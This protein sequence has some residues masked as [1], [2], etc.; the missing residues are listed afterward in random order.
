MISTMISSWMC[1]LI[2]DVIS[3]VRRMGPW[4][5]CVWFLSPCAPRDPVS[6]LFDCVHLV[7]VCL[8]NYPRLVLYLKC[9][10]FL[11]SF[12]WCRPY[13]VLRVC[14]CQALCYPLFWTIKDCYP[15]SPSSPRS[16][17]PHSSTVTEH[18]TKQKI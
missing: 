7:Q 9:C 5:V 11:D 18:R 15:E 16:F 4:T 1:H 2:S 10:L 6:P 13:Y 8:V 17:V 14:S 3:D 12:V